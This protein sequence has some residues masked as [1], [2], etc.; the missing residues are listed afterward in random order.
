MTV[1]GMADQSAFVV[2][3]SPRTL[4]SKWWGKMGLNEVPSWVPG[5]TSTHWGSHI[6]WDNMEDLLAFT[7][8]TPLDYKLFDR[9]RL[10]YSWSEPL[11]LV[12][13]QPIRHWSKSRVTVISLVMYSSNTTTTTVIVVAVAV[14]VIIALAAHP[15]LVLRH[16]LRSYKSKYKIFSQ[17]IIE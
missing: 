16:T 11:S 14:A 2:Q 6:F 4:T 8:I 13:K 17:D 12:S 9:H 15:A 7:G 10:T 5:I 1:L 3:R